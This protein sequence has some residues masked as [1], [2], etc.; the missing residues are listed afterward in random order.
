M[1][2]RLARRQDVLGVN[3][4]VLGPRAPPIGGGVGWGAGCSLL[5]E[6]VT[7]GD[8]VWCMLSGSVC[9]DLP[10]KCHLAAGKK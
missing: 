10:A 7:M 1:F 8:E 4:V 9:W 6:K 5:L 3:H 2:A